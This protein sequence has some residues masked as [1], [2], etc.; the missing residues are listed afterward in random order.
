MVKRVLPIDMNIVP[1][2]TVGQWER[3]I[4]KAY[5]TGA[6]GDTNLVSFL[7]GEVPGGYDT[8]GVPSQYYIVSSERGGLQF[9]VMCDCKAGQDNRPCYH[10]AAVVIRSGYITEVE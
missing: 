7:S 5:Q 1:G 3:A 8:H 4:N 6:V 10:A 2:S 9:R